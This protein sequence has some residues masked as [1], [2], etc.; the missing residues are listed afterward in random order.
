MDS[1]H[2]CWFS[3]CYA[4]IR[5]YFPIAYTGS[6]DSF[7]LVSKQFH[8]SV[9]IFVTQFLAFYRLIDKISSFLLLLTPTYSH[10]FSYIS[11]PLP[12]LP[13]SLSNSPSPTSSVF[14]F[15]PT[16]PYFYSFKPLSVSQHVSLKTWN[17][18][19][20]NSMSYPLL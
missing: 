16:L 11:P 3:A 17:G 2:A 10:F 9:K 4:V 13:P 18:P 1:L 19:L 15:S 5:Y 6:Y 20:F 14:T 12:S 7:Y 8:Y